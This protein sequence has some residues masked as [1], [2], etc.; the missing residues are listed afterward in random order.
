MSQ[1]ASLVNGLLEEVLAI[2]EEKKEMSSAADSA[3]LL[4]L[5]ATFANDPASK[6]SKYDIKDQKYY[7]TVAIPLLHPDWVT[8]DLGYSTILLGQ[9]VTTTVAKQPGDLPK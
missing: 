5:V 3:T 8:Q 6:A 2:L 9:Y 4:S 1:K 7:Y